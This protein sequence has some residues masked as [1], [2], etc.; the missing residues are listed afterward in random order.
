M[1]YR[2]QYNSSEYRGLLASSLAA[3]AAEDRDLAI[4]SLEGHVLYTSRRLLA[5]FSPAL[6]PLLASSHP[7]TLTT[8]LSL[9]YSSSTLTAL[10]SL[11]TSGLASCSSPLG[12]EVE[13]L[14]SLLRIPINFTTPSATPWGVKRK[15]TSL[16]VIPVKEEVEPPLE[17]LDATETPSRKDGKRTRRKG[18]SCAICQKSFRQKDRLSNHMA[19]SHPEVAAES[20]VQGEGVE[21]GIG[22]DQCGKQFQTAEQLETH[23]KIHLAGDQHSCEVCDKTFNSPKKLRK[24]QESHS[25]PASHECEVCHKS[26]QSSGTLR[27]H[28]AIHL[29]EKPFKC[30]LCEWQG[31]QKGNF[32]IH[33]RNRHGEDP[34]NILDLSGAPVTAE[35]AQ[36]EDA[37]ELEESVVGPDVEEE[38]VMEEEM[39]EE[40]KMNGV[41][42]G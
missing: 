10:L 14:A 1:T 30:H 31:T 29:P 16:S 41:V 23:G 24:H 2:L 5:L 19:K 26:F 21:A 40:V 36:D 12:R 6:A 9:P 32:K 25:K 8:S 35:V 37:E 27:M 13:E 34:D 3:W 7:T 20:V 4:V 17:E 39:E 42:E 33:L 18:H 38:S 11:L 22:C 15:N 28:G